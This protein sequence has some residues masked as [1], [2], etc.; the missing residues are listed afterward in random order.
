MSDL[1]IKIIKHKTEVSEI[2]EEIQ[3]VVGLNFDIIVLEKI[4]IENNYE[5]LPTIACIL[6]KYK[7]FNLSYYLS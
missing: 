6:G 7:F 1:K 3:T 5:F 4:L 2:I